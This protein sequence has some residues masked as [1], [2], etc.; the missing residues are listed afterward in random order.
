M[1]S[2]RE[3]VGNLESIRAEKLKIREQDGKKVAYDPCIMAAFKR[4]DS[5]LVRTV[6]QLEKR[7][8]GLTAS[9]LNVSLEGCSSLP[10]FSVCHVCT[11][12]IFTRFSNYTESLNMW[13]SLLKADNLSQLAYRYVVGLVLTDKFLNKN[14]GVDPFVPVH[15]KKRERISLFNAFAKGMVDEAFLADLRYHGSLC[16]D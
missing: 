11:A 13:E 5:M 2:L 16:P 1:L 8:E 9:K 12:H 14:E 3:A 4:C 7:Y 15:P 6:E 10:T